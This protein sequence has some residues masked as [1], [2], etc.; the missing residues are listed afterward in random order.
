MYLLEFFVVLNLFQDLIK[1]KFNN[2]GVTFQVTLS[3]ISFLKDE[4]KNALSIAKTTVL[5]TI[6]KH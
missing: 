5:P 3:T 6:L 4:E 2:M 1:F